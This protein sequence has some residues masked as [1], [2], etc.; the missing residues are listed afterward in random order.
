MRKCLAIHI[1]SKFKGLLLGAV[2]AL[3]LTSVAQAA[4]LLYGE[5]SED[6]VWVLAAV[7]SGG[8]EEVDTEL[9]L[10]IRIPPGG[11]GW[12]TNDFDAKVI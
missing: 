1:M 9:E 2:A 3:S 10:D 11:N 4:E 5:V 12:L 8:D 6:D 7:E